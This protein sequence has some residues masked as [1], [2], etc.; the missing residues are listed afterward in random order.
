MKNAHLIKTHQYSTPRS[1]A[2]KEMAIAVLLLLLAAS[3]GINTYLAVKLLAV[4]SSIQEV[5]AHD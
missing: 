2:D 1:V 4:Q 3:L 5:H